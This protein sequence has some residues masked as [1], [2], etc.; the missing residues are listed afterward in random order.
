MKNNNTDIR[1][2]PNYRALNSMTLLL[3]LLNDVQETTLMNMLD[4]FK[5]NNIKYKTE[6]EHK[7]KKALIEVRR[8]KKPIEKIDFNLQCEFGDVADSMYQL[9]YN[10]YVA[11]GGYPEEL[12]KINNFV[13]DYA[14]QNEVL[15]NEN[16]K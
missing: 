4:E 9:I 12:A 16:R 1:K 7:T 10:I 11:T 14:K 8:L 13:I 2:L 6:L 3:F 5:K 15:N